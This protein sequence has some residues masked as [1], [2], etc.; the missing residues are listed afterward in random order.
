[1]WLPIVLSCVCLLVEAFFSSA[2]I[3]IVSADRA[4]IRDLAATGHR[5]ARLVEEFLIAPH[6][7]LSATLLGTQMAV[8]LQTV[9]WTLWLHAHHPRHVE[10]LL[11]VG[12]TPAVVILGEIIPKAIVRQH[13]NRLA[14]LQARLLSALAATGVVLGAVYMLYLYQRVM[15]GPLTNPQNRKLQD[16]SARET[17][18][19]LPMLAMAFWLGICPNT[20]LKHIDPAVT[21][22]LTVFKDKYAA[23]AAES[24][25]RMLG[26]AAKAKVAEPA[27]GGNP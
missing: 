1:M 14:P 9:V 12:L 5:G 4:H 25:A 7:L 23:G 13:A 19:M 26:E 24:D 20:F 22:T 11:L 3:A 16:M 15:L 10:L 2:E 21:Q 8:V 17:F 6:R 27:P 18:V